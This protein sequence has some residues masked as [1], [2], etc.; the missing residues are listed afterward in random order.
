MLALFSVPPAFCPN[1]GAPIKQHPEDWASRCAFFCFGCDLTYQ[2]ADESTIL[3]AATESGGE[4][5][6]AV[7]RA[8]N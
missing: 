3:K 7:G 1:C 2:G 8:D 5:A 4:L 6:R